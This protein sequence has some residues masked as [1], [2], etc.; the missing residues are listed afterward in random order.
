MMLS[1]SE[2]W[3]ALAWNGV[4]LRVPPHWEVNLL[5]MSYL[6]LSDGFGPVMEIKWQRLKD[7]FSHEA[8][9]RKLAKHYSSGS[10]LNFQQ[11]P[12][13]EEW[14]KALSRFEAQSFRWHGT[15]ISGEGAIIYCKTCKRATLVQFYH[16]TGRDD[17]LVSLAVLNSLRDHSE[18]G[19]VKWALFGLRASIPERFS[20][21]RHRFHPGH[22]QL[23]F[24]DR[25]EH[26]HLSRW[27]PA[28]VLLEDGDLQNW[29][30]KRCDDFRWCTT[31]R[32]R[33][34]ED[35]RNPTLQ[36]QSQQTDRLAAR[37]WARLSGK[38]P[39]FWIRIWHLHARNQILGVG[40]RGLRPLDE[41]WL[42]DICISYEMV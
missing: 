5:D 29:F 16:K 18:D 1:P 32:F 13:P 21:R 41:Q 11:I 28:E 19:L 10:R 37:L 40:A 25:Q 17:P 12:L 35:G 30:E 42:E 34:I 6:Q 15:K 39:H 27:G 24:Q 36:G 31:T 38:P 22:Y 9:L 23:L 20:L 8:Q 26:L 14:H 4:S 2:E 33:K 3:K 7:D